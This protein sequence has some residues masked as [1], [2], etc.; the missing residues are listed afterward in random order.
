MSLR[1]TSSLVVLTSTSTLI[2]GENPLRRALIVQVKSGPAITLKF[3]GDINVTNF[4]ISDGITV[5]DTII[6]D[7]FCPTSA[8]YM[9]SSAGSTCLIVEIV[10]EDQ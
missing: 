6:L 10:A 2:A 5:S 3:G 8:Y 9:N 4:G 1:T 7:K